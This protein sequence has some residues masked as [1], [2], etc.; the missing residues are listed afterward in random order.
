MISLSKKGT[1]F[2]FI[3]DLVLV[4]KNGVGRV[5]KCYDFRQLHLANTC[6]YT[7]T[8]T[9][10]FYQFYSRLHVSALIVRHHVS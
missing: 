7:V 10:S 2:L 1:K 4:K 6:T 9:T 5:F 8:H 3:V